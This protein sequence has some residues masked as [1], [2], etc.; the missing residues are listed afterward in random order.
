VSGAASAN[1]K[2]RSEPFG[3]RLRRWWRTARG[4]DETMRDFL[5]VVEF[6]TSDPNFPVLVLRDHVV[7]L[8]VASGTDYMYAPD[9]L[10]RSIYEGWGR[11]LT[12]AELSLQAFVDVRP[13]R[14]DLPGG[15]VEVT[16]QMIAD[17]EEREHEI[18]ATTKTKIAE[19]PWREERVESFVNAVADG[20]L[21]EAFGRPLLELRQLV[22][23]RMATGAVERVPDPDDKKAPMYYPRRRSWKVWEQPEFRYLGPGG[24][25][26]WIADR[27]RAVAYLREA[28]GR[29]VNDAAP[30]SRFRLRPAT[31]I[32]VTQL[33]HLLWNGEAAQAEWIGDFAEMDSYRRPEER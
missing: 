13:L 22:A 19:D 26:A 28:A 2:K 7:C 18:A 30:I 4:E 32:E 3:S 14:H 20:A 8:M 29:I 27:E 16:R 5:G 10:R 33:L 11:L 31:A 9:A 6:D 17:I 15:I 25:T 24:R 12:N 23:V 21:E 1:T